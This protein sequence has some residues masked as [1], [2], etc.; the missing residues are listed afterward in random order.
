M[1]AMQ[2]GRIR[3]TGGATKK[4]IS[5]LLL[6]I[7]LISIAATY[8]LGQEQLTRGA[9]VSQKVKFVKAGTRVV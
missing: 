5:T 8:F 2:V 9:E 3:I 1:S 6:L 7:A 4:I